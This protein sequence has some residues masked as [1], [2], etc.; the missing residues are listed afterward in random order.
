MGDSSLD[1]NVSDA[2]TRETDAP[3]VTPAPQRFNGA[4]DPVQGVGDVERY[5]PVVSTASRHGTLRSD[6]PIPANK[7]SV[8]PHY[9]VPDPTTNVA[10]V[11]ERLVIIIMEKIGYLFIVAYSQGIT[12][13]RS[14][15][16]QHMR[17]EYEERSA[18]C[19][20]VCVSCLCS[21][22]RCCG[23]DVSTYAQRGMYADDIEA[24]RSD[25]EVRPTKQTRKVVM[26]RGGGSGSP[27]AATGT[28]QRTGTLFSQRVLE[29]AGGGWG[30]WR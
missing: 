7:Q 5:H 23:Y 11:S 27:P 29:A 22:V 6:Q 13:K 3:N 9:G 10:L 4:E 21:K 1:L 30:E 16:Q 25:E 2:W 15:Q 20:Y 26:P 19:V 24:S 8:T 14:T 18:V 17:A 28:Q 12:I